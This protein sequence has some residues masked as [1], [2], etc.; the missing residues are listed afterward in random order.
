MAKDQDKAG[1]P[2]GATGETVLANIRRIRADV[3]GIAVTELSRRLGEL[4]RPI[5]PLGIR[6]IE[7]GDRRV[8]VDDLMS[9]AV[10]LGVSPITLLM[11]ES[12]SAEDAVTFTG[13]DEQVPAGHAWKWLGGDLPLPDSGESV[14]TFYAR[15]VPA[16]TTKTME[17]QLLGERGLRSALREMIDQMDSTDGD[18]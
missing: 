2:L 12:A 14:L 3:L 15:A 4:G 8:D 11:P 7:S 5:P 18:D 16:W 6:R 1:R 17:Q 13:R 9:L 10:A